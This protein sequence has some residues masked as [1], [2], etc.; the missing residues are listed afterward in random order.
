MSTANKSNVIYIH[1]ALKDHKYLELLEKLQ[2][3]CLIPDLA[4]WWPSWEADFA[5][6]AA[7]EEVLGYQK[8]LEL[9]VLKCPLDLDQPRYDQE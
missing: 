4:S 9:L 6:A 1:G 8:A 2:V 3:A 5:A 7:T